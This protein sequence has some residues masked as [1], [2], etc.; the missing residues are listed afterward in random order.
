MVCR[1]CNGEVSENAG[2]ED[3]PLC[4]SCYNRMR[5]E[6][7]TIS[8]AP[9][10]KRSKWPFGA[11]LLFLLLASVTAAYFYVHTPQ[12]AFKAIK[13]AV[14]NHDWNKFSRFVDVE[15]FYQT[16]MK[17]A[18]DDSDNSLA[19]G[20]GTLMAANM[21]QAFIDQLKAQIEQPSED[22][23]SLFQSLFD[24]DKMVASKM[25]VANRGKIVQVNVP[26]KVSFLDI[27]IPVVFTFRKEPLHLTL[28]G[29]D[30]SKYDAAQERI[31]EILSDHYVLPARDSLNNLVTIETVRKY[32]G[33][34]NWLYKTCMDKLIMIT[35]RVT[36]NSD[37][38][39]S[40][41][42][43]EIFPDRAW[44]N[45]AL[46]KYQSATNIKAG[47]SVVT[48]T[49]QGWKYN[50]FSEDDRI[51]MNADKSEIYYK[52]T[53][54]ELASGRS[55]REN[56]YAYLSDYHEDKPSLDDIIARR[57]QYGIEDGD[58]IRKELGIE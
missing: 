37:E 14:E 36:N 51:F 15:S 55:I 27:E 50:Q 48:G 32:D 6:Y 42:D 52:V 31:A 46:K 45:S 24:Q 43:F 47:Q 28:T 41:V 30:M 35:S 7:S 53:N 19:K 33:C 58:L 23:T 4:E 39:I 18:L 49:K 26:R 9:K 1:E 56:K 2:T 54:V 11:I 34:S 29:M 20:I 12:Y 17:D 25:D 22:G 16:T 5:E 10:T 40:S 57:E 21:K 3:N 44:R 8:N 38:D 13:G